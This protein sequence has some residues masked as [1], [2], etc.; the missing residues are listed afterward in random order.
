MKSRVTSPEFTKIKASLVFSKNI[1][2]VA[3]RFKR[4]E[5]TITKI[6]TS[7]NYE[8][9]RKLVTAE[10]PPERP[11]TLGRKF[12]RAIATLLRR[13]AISEQD[14]DYINTG[15]RYEPDTD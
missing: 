12:N 2:A 15:R 10:H 8:A 13:E 4:S 9:Y 14:R 3:V 1:R 6:L 11:D 7:K 5:A